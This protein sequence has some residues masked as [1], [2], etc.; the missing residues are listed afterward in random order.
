MYNACNS[1]MLSPKLSKFLGI[2]ALGCPC[3][4]YAQLRLCWRRVSY[5][6]ENARC[7][8]NTAFV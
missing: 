6:V 8:R 7:W 4:P 5:Q 2:L 1:V 3:T